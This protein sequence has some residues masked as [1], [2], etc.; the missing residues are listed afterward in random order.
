MDHP[1]PSARLRQPRHRP[2]QRP[3]DLEGAKPTAVPLDLG[4][5][6]GREGIWSSQPDHQL[7]VEC[8]DDRPP[9]RDRVP[10]GL[11]ANR[12]TMLDHDPVDPVA[13]H[14]HPAGVADGRGQGGADS[15]AAALGHRHADPLPQQVHDQRVHAAATDLGLQVGMHPRADQERPRLLGGEPV[16]DGATALDDQPAQLQEVPRAQPAQQPGPVAQR[17]AHHPGP[18]QRDHPVA[19]PFV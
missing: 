12:P 7:R 8:G 15:A 5:A 16:G 19:E 1:S 9:R 14:D 17:P 3:V 13:G 18:H 4:Q 10:A 6:A 11:D 2:V